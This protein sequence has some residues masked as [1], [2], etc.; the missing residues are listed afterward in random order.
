VY[1]VACF[2]VSGSTGVGP[3]RTAKRFNS[4]VGQTLEDYHPFVSVC[5]AMSELCK[6]LVGKVR[7]FGSIEMV[8]KVFG[9]IEMVPLNFTR[10]RQA[11]DSRPLVALGRGDGPEARA[12]RHWPNCRGPSRGF[13]GGAAP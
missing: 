7:V 8:P 6:Y 13:G 9:S 11:V 4:L 2:V 5:Y 12:A 1:Y 3:F 10:V